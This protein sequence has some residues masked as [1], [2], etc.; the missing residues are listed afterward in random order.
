MSITEA[1]LLAYVDGEL[2]AADRARVEA[3]IQSDDLLA[4]RVA[5]QRGLRAR[6]NASYNAVLDEAVPQRLLDV[7]APDES[8]DATVTDIAQARAERDAA[9][10]PSPPAPRGRWSWREW[11]A[12]AASVLLGVL[13]GPMVLEGSQ[14]L[15]LIERDGRIV[16]T[17]ELDNVMMWTLARDSNPQDIARMGV[18]IRDKQ[19]RFCRS[20]LLRQGPSGLACRENGV[21]IIEALAGSSGQPGK[22]AGLRQAATDLPEFLRLAIEAR[23]DGEPLDSNAEWAAIQKRWRK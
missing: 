15:P 17:G 4:R 13:L 21:W 6:L 8:H 18:S 23:M 1:E 9:A 22:D 16:A 20:F 2:D 7:L 19:G 11:S 14:T 10:S 12:I 5:T 3:A